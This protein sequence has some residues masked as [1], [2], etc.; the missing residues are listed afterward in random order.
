[1]GLYPVSRLDR[2]FAELLKGVMRIAE[3]GV[4][5]E[6]GRGRMGMTLL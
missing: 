3:M 4:M 2:K 1:M 5:L 6:M